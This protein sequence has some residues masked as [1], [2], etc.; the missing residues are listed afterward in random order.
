MMRRFLILPR[1]N[2]FSDDHMGVDRPC[3]YLGL[4]QELYIE[5]MFIPI[6]EKEQHFVARVF[7][8]TGYPHS[9]DAARDNPVF[10]RFWISHIREKF[11]H[12]CAIKIAL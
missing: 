11:K 9:F 3:L 10:S 8:D 12:F 7:E 1:S 6:V 2:S 4:A 5:N